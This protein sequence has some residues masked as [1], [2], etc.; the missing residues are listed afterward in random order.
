MDVRITIPIIRTQGSGEGVA[1]GREN[2]P[3]RDRLII[4]LPIGRETAPLII[5][6]PCPFDHTTLSNPYIHHRECWTVKV[7]TMIIA[8]LNTLGLREVF[9]LIKV[10]TGLL[11]T[12]HRYRVP[13]VPKMKVAHCISVIV[14]LT[15][16]REDLTRA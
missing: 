11:T 10:G 5:R 3:A 15:K 16:L 7:C 2:T 6:L 12:V 13:K 4:H 9:N 14:V 1:D 8:R